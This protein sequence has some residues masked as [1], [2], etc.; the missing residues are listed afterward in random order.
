MFKKKYVKEE[1][2]K[3]RN[4]FR[5]AI[6]GIFSA[7]ESEANMKIHIFIMLLVIILGLFLKLSLNEWFACIL[8][9]CLVI[10]SELF[11]TALE[12]V[13]NLA[14]PHVNPHAKLAKDLSAG[15]VLVFA[16]GAVVIGCIIFLPKIIELFT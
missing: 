12:E 7:F 11:N 1:I 9:F 4:S 6:E 16:L 14:S 15:A 3:R 8:L 2:K 5:Y 13:V 10:G